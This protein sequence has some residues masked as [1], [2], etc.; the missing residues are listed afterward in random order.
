MREEDEV[1]VPVGYKDPTLTM[2]FP[3]DPGFCD[4]LDDCICELCDELSHWIVKFQATIDDIVH[5]SNI[6]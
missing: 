1:L 3:P 2:P 6:H 5:R 4:G